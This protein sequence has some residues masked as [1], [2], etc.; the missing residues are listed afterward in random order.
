M[1]Y[2]HKNGYKFLLS[3]VLTHK[4][5]TN[6]LLEGWVNQNGYFMKEIGRAGAKYPRIEVIVKN[7]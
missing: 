7:Y 2:L 6:E 5:Q 1:D 4:G 3:N